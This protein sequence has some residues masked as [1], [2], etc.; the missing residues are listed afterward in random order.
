MTAAARKAAKRPP[1]RPPAEPVNDNAK[2]EELARQFA[3]ATI[4]AGAI[5]MSAGAMRGFVQAAREMLS[6]VEKPTPLP[7]PPKPGE[8]RMRRGGALLG[9]PG[10]LLE[11]LG[12]ER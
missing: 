10:D 7:P 4:S 6:E 8:Q 5:V 12:V 3:L 1:G 9:D 11:E 2:V